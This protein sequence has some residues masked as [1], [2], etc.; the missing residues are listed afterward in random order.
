LKSSMWEKRPWRKGIDRDCGS[1]SM[2]GR[3][4]LVQSH[5]DFVE[6]KLRAGNTSR[7][8]VF[9]RSP[10]GLRAR[11][12]LRRVAHLDDPGSGRGIGSNCRSVP[13]LSA[14][15]PSACREQS[16]RT[17]N[18]SSRIRSLRVRFRYFVA[19]GL[20]QSCAGDPRYIPDIRVRTLATASRLHCPCG[21]SYY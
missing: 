15:C 19:G 10:R 17:V 12:A 11:D 1:R 13:R 20:C 5:C 8:V 4:V 2:G 6:K 7:Y 3:L 18:R 14:D 16:P 9:R 21:T